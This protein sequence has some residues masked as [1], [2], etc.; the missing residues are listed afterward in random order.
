MT[1][2]STATRTTERRSPWMD[3]ELEAVA[4]LARNFFAKHVTPHQKRF[5]SQ[6]FPDKS[7]Y[8]KLG[9]LGLAGMSI[10]TEYGGGGG[11]FAHDA[12]L[13]HEQVMAGDHSL[14]LGVHS[15][16]VPHYLNAYADHEHKLRWLPKLV[17]GEWVGAIAMTEPGTGS[18]LQN[19]TTR[20]VRDGDDYLIS[21]A[22]TF[23]SNGRNCDL[24]IIAAKTDPSLGAR[25]V[26]LIVAEVD[27]NTPGFERG[28]ILEK[29]GQKGQDTTEL[30]FDRLRVPATNLLGDREGTG[31]AQLMQQLLPERLICGVAATAA[32]ERAVALTVEYTKSRNMFGQT[33]FD[34]QNTRFELAE[35]ASIARISRTFIDDCIVKYLAGRLDATTAAMAKYWLTDQQ[36][37]VIDRCVQLHG[38]Y[39][40]ILEYPIAQMYADAR[41]QRIYA[42]SNEVMK[43]LVARS[44]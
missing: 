23:I 30:F 28:R 7:A 15:G 26:S 6:G 18:D 12:V 27:D 19:I 11:T 31:F 8:R 44:L 14:Q 37:A 24:V 42:G 2:G 10:P 38:G 17:S 25:G 9:T 35:C 16:I 4:D 1:Q 20:A 36:C 33:L 29:V 22:K 13:F 43:D 21:G 34:L 39:G 32:M 41:I 40:Y 3:D 5:A